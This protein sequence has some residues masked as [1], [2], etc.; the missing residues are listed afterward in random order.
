[1]TINEMM[2]LE[3]NVRVCDILKLFF[4]GYNDKLKFD[5]VEL[6]MKHW[7]NDIF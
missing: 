7:T 1:M 2:A 5:L 6:D 4:D 3:L